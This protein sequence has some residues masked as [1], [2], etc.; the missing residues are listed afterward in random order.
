MPR[1]SGLRDDDVL[2]RL[3]D[4]EK[5]LDALEEPAEKPKKDS[6]EK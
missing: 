1:R 2:G 6:K 5:R 4:L 3:A